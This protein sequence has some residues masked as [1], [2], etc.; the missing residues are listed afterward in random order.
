MA[1]KTRACCAG[2][3]TGSSINVIEYITI[4]TTGDASDFGDLTDNR[5]SAAAMSGD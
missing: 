5:N 3:Y 1:N 4:D 2:G